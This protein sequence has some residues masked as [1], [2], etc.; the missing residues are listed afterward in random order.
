MHG[1]D[2]LVN[3]ATRRYG[4]LGE[5]PANLNPLDEFGGLSRTLRRLRLKEWI[6]FTLTHPEWASSMILQD[7]GYL[8]SSEIYAGE[9]GSGTLHQHSANAAG[10]SLRLP[11]T[12]T[13]SDPGFRKSGYLLEY[14]FSDGDA[15]HRIRVDIAATAAAPAFTAELEL[16]GGRASAPLSVSHKMP[17]GRLYTHK[18]L[19]PVSGTLRVGDSEIVFDPSR[20]LAILDEHKSFLPYRTRWVW[21][22]FGAPAGGRPA[23][24][25]FCERP[26]LPG[27]EE[28]SCLWLPGSCEPLS[29][30]RFAPEADGPL[31]AWTMASADGRL[32][33]TFTPQG[34]KDVRHQLGLFEI[35]YFQ[36]YGTYRG[37]MRSAG[38]T[39]YPV[40]G[41]PG[42]CES[43][44][45]RL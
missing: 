13:G 32:D 18:A 30:V 15:P 4:R 16:H 7:A 11:E 10:G 44:R 24:A 9:R 20:D 28:E 1:G 38:G 35:D 23:G 43:M 37:T 12:L 40:T 36:L 5:R 33:V 31:A 3:G 14:Q 22:T 41:A 26:S 17:G 19:F 29:G 6:G 8:A 42:V 2:C 25:N 21:G 34:R 27:E 39:S 45:A